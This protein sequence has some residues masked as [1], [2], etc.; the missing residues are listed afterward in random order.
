MKDGHRIDTSLKPKLSQRKPGFAYLHVKMESRVKN[1]C[2][3]QAAT[4]PGLCFGFSCG[5][6]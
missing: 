4:A 5:F 1:L 3:I 6:A 2:P